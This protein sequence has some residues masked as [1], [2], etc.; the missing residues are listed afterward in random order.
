MNLQRART[1]EEYIEWVKSARFEI[2]DLKECILFET[3]HMQSFPSWL[4]ELETGLEKIYQDMCAGNYAFGRDDLPYMPAVHKYA[5][6][7]PFHTLLK[8]I[9]ETHRNG[10]DVPEEEK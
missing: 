3:D 2:G 7:I 4:E 6:D 9:N 5:H 1:V 10:L 8:Q